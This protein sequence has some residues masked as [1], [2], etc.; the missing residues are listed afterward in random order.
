MNGDWWIN[1][2]IISSECHSS[3]NEPPA[4]PVR[5]RASPLRRVRAPSGPSQYASQRDRSAHRRRP[6][7]LLK[8]WALHRRKEVGQSRMPMTSWVQREDQAPPIES[9]GFHP[10]F[11]TWFQAEW[12]IVS[13]NRNSWQVLV[14]LFIVFICILSVT[15]TTDYWVKLLVRLINKVRSTDTVY[16]RQVSKKYLSNIPGWTS[17]AKFKRSS[18]GSEGCNTVKRTMSCGKTYKM[19]YLNTILNSEIDTRLSEISMCT[20]DASIPLSRIDIVTVESVW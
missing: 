18:L 3:S 7:L 20:L 8:L 11:S 16:C 10:S 19:I 2:W 9:I 17:W 1:T 12:G 4:A 5:P 13:Y 6:L 14:K 15:K